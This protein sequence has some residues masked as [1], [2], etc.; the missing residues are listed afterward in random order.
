MGSIPHGAPQ[1]GGGQFSPLC[2]LCSLCFRPNRKESRPYSQIRRHRKHRQSET[3]PPH[4]LIR[5]SKLCLAYVWRSVANQSPSSHSP[6]AAGQKRKDPERPCQGTEQG[7]GGAA[8][9][10]FRRQDCRPTLQLQDRQTSD[11]SW[12]RLLFVAQ[13]FASASLW[14]HAWRT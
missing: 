5:K 1:G 8:L 11:Q 4:G 7:Q 12:H 10:K 13:S 6:A 2:S 9:I 3:E 14:F